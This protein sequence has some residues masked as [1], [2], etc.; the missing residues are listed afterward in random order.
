MSSVKEGDR[1]GLITYFSLHKWKKIGSW[2]HYAVPAVQ[3][4]ELYNFKGYV[5]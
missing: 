2:D 5:V 1:G 3:L 4:S